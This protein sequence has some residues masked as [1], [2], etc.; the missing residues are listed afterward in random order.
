MAPCTHYCYPLSPLPPPNQQTIPIC[1]LFLRRLQL[2]TCR[3]M[4]AVKSA[5][6]SSFIIFRPSPMLL[7]CSS[8]SPCWH[9]TEG[10]HAGGTI[11]WTKRMPSL[12]CC[13]HHHLE[14]VYLII[15]EAG[16]NYWLMSM[17]PTNPPVASA[18]KAPLLPLNL[19]KKSRELALVS[20]LTI[21]YQTTEIPCPTVSSFQQPDLSRCQFPFLMNKEQ[22]P[23]ARFCNRHLGHWGLTKAPIYSKAH[24]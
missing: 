19:P 14:K 6:E 23:N 18:C 9:S 22:I 17:Q 24:L 21:Q 3:W 10:I 20:L 7:D 12:S 16:K 1:L 8:P 13:N 2:S 11:C 15:Q 5:T 4:H